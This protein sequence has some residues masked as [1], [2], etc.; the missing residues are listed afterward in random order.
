MLLQFKYDGSSHRDCTIDENNKMITSLIIY[1]IGCLR[2]YNIYRVAASHSKT[3][4]FHLFGNDPRIETYFPVIINICSICLC[5]KK[6]MITRK[7]YISN[8]VN[9]L[10]PK[11]AFVV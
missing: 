2:T 9:I 4:K 10:Q 5:Q 1:S 11:A 6:I 8:K 3:H 7:E